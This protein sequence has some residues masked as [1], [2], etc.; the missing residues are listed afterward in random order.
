M[1]PI[2]IAGRCS[3]VRGAGAMSAAQRLAS[4]ARGMKILSATPV[5]DGKQVDIEFVDKTAY[6][7]HTAWIKD[8]HPSLAGSD[9]YR[10]SAR[11]LFEVDKYTADR[12]QPVD[13]GSKLMVH[14]KN[15]SAEN[16]V[17]EEYVGTWLHA[18]APYVGLPLHDKNPIPAKEDGLKN[19]GSLLDKLY[20][21]RKGWASELKMPTFDGQKLM[22]DEDMQIEFLERMMDPGAALVTNIGV[23]EN[24]DNEKAGVPMEDFVSRVIGRLNQ[25]PVRA[26]RYGII[27]T[28]PKAEQAGADYD[29]N[30]PLSMHTDHSVYNGTPGYLQ[31]MYQAQGSVTSKV[32]D[33][34][35][36]ANYM[37]EHHPEEYDLLTTVHLTHSSRN[38]IYARNGAYRQD[39]S[40]SE[41]AT[42]ELVH[43]HPVLQLD[44]D[45][46]LEKVVQSETKRGVCA[47]PFDKYEKYMEAYKRWTDLVEDPKFTCKFDWPEHSVIV[48][49][50]WRVLHGR[51]TVPPNTQRTM[52]FGYVMKTIV[53][54]R[55][56]LLKQR[57]TQKRNPEMDEKWLTRLPNQVLHSLVH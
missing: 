26:T 25:H 33:G 50:N 30:N 38:C 39:T 3:L 13:D 40:D 29:H 15:G 2:C 28:K 27:H 34:L 41:G 19:T 35:T 44:Q 54:N 56:R 43:T 53:E 57:Q 4:G 45:G 1:I 7:F 6:R 5:N 20:Q 10:K 22:V 24:L 23:P 49:N 32:C 21:N 36:I 18:F 51:A 9:F 46:H 47:L 8:A 52:I 12:A 16:A 14:F 37:K 48:M 31:F 17:S 55:Y 11:T 42:F